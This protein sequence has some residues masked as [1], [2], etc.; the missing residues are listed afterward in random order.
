MC[1]SICHR[2][3]YAVACRSGGDPGGGRCR[4]DRGTRRDHEGGAQSHAEGRARPGSVV[5]TPVVKAPGV[6]TPGLT[7]PKVTVPGVALPPIRTPVVTVPGVVVPP[8]TVPPVTVPP[9]TVP[10][11]V[12][13]AIG[14]SVLAG[15]GITNTGPTTHLGRHRH[16]P[17]DVDHRP[18]RR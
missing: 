4:D 13:P 16:V 6:E 1:A 9:V 15:A 3:P 12:M 7:T 14:F 10:P 18:R 11:I 5:K 17:D 2:P 8:V